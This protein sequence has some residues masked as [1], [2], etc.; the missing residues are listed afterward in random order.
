[1]TPDDRAALLRDFEEAPPWVLDRDWSLAEARN[2]MIL[3][4]RTFPATVPL[5]AERKLSLELFRIMKHG[6]TR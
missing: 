5:S 1:M 6:G 4:R 2:A 3:R